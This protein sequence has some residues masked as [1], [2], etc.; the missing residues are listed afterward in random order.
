MHTS[1]LLVIAILFAF[2]IPLA[3]RA[4]SNKLYGGHFGLKLGANLNRITISG[5]T[6]NIPK[7]RLDLVLGGMYR[8]RINKFVAQPEVLLSLKGANFQTEVTG[9][10]RATT[11]ISY[12]YLSVPLLLGYIP[13]EGLTIQAGPELSYAITGGQSGGPGATTDIG[14][15]LGIHYDFLDMLDKFSLNLRYIYGFNN[16]SPEAGANYYNRVFQA[17]IVYNLYPKKKK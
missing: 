5:T 2:A 15:V 9:G 13:T 4:Q 8:Y 12:P 16:V 1:R 7:Q 14:A 17:A 3:A 6:Q 10:N 11:K